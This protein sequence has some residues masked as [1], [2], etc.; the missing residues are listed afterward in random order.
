MDHEL[1]TVDEKEVVEKWNVGKLSGKLIAASN[2]DD[3]LIYD[4]LSLDD[5]LYNN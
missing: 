5:H 4:L 2:M 1:I 3:A